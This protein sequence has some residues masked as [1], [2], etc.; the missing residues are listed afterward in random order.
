MPFSA[1]NEERPLGGLVPARPLADDVATARR[2]LTLPDGYPTA[3][4]HHRPL[5]AP[6]EPGGPVLYAHGIQ[7]HPGWFV[8]SAQ[9]LARA[10]H[11]V[12][13]VTRRGSGDAATARGDAPSAA[14]LIADTAA[15]VEWIRA[16]TGADRVCLL[17]VSW[18]G[19]L[20]VLHA[21]RRPETVRSLTLVAPGIKPSVGVGWPVRLAIAA[22]RLCCSRR[23]FDIPL[24]DPALFTDSPDM[25]RYLREDPHRLHR[26]TARLLVASALL[27]RR[28]ARAKAGSVTAP[29][30]LLLARRDR[31][32]DN[33]ATG[34]L[35]E[36]LTAGAVRIT[37]FDAAHT[38]E[39]EPD[40]GGF[41]DALLAAVRAE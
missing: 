33:A 14:A 13:Q 32:I 25:Q 15:A 26:A 8:G 6:A 24:N 35:L 29:T 4:I 34:R 30:S 41:Y 17:G 7:S 20:M 40:V 28:V 18:G 37:E 5:P 9:A 16:E 22:C 38:I 2:T 19:K 10:G 21:I 31:I 1:E 23:R 36:R 12:F 3:V 11:E 27:D 39:F